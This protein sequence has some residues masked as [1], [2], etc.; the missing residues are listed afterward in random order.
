MM[1]YASTRHTAG[2]ALLQLP[3]DGIDLMALSADTCKS[4]YIHLLRGEFHV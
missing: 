4:I 2:K 3:R 1:R